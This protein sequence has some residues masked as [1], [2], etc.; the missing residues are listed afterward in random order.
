MSLSRR[1]TFLLLYIGASSSIVMTMTLLTSMYREN[2]KHEA[3]ITLPIPSHSNIF[4]VPLEDLMGHNGEKGGVPKVVR[5]CIQYLRETGGLLSSSY[6]DYSLT[7][8]V[9][10]CVKKVFFDVLPSLLCFAPP[11]RHTTEVCT[12]PHFETYPTE[13]PIAGNIVSLQTF[14]DPHIATVLLK[15]FLR[16]LPDPII[17]ERLY[18]V[19]Q[20][21]PIP[22]SDPSDTSSIHYI[23]ETLLPELAPCAYI[24]L[25]HIFCE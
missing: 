8:L 2:L 4:G 15:K 7:L 17:P 19:I 1:S 20:R 14:G 12:A 18:P 3:R 23:R 25:S 10:G 16:D 9:Q 6:S 21:C 24:L 11:R 22:S 5:D 13:P